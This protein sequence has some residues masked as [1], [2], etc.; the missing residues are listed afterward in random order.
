MKILVEGLSKSGTSALVYKIYNSLPR[1]DT[2]LLFE[3]PRCVDYFS[4]NVVAKVLIDKP[5]RHAYGPMQCSDPVYDLDSYDDFKKILIIRDPKDRTVSDKL[6]RLY[7]EPFYSDDLFIRSVVKFLREKE[8]N[9]GG[10]LYYNFWRFIIEYSRF[11][12]MLLDELP[13]FEYR[14]FKELL[15]NRMLLYIKDHPDLFILHYEDFIDGKLEPL[16]EYLGLKLTGEAQV[17]E[18]MKRVERT[19]GY[20]DYKNWF[21][22]DDIPL[23]QPI[24]QQFIDA[25]PRYDNWS[26][27]DGPDKVLLSKY[28]SGYVLRLVNERRRFKGLPPI[29]E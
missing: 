10:I 16:E 3:E 9:P 7:H 26:L 14:E 25:Y 12:N 4:K 17:G 22:P 24:F 19:K 27:N 29:M 15:E 20:G 21:T 6:Y 1:A 5:L 28:G 2:T 23:F 11:S 8:A 18:G 13:T